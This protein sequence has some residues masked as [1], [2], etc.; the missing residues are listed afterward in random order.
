MAQVVYTVKKGD[1]L[2]PIAKKYGVT[3]EQIVKLNNLKKNS[4][5]NY[6]IYVG[7][8]LIISGSTTSAGSSGSTGGSSG[9][10]GGSSGSTGGSGSSSVVVNNNKPI[11][12]LFGLQSDTDRSI[13]ATW[14]WSK[15]H[16]D[17]YEVEWYYDSGDNVWFKGSIGTETLQQSIY[18]APS[19]AQRVKFRVK[20]VSE[21]YKDSNDKEISYWT[22]EFSTEKIY[23]F[24]ALP[25]AP[26]V[27][28][29]SVEGMKLTASISNL[30]S[31]TEKVSFE[32]V[33]DD[34]T[35][36][37][38]VRVPVITT[39]AQVIFDISPGHRYKVRAKTW[40]SKFSSEWSNYSDNVNTLP[41]STTNIILLKA[42]STTSVYIE[43]TKEDTA[44]SYEIEYSTERRYLENTSSSS[45]KTITGITNTKYEIEGLESGKEYFF[46]VR[47]VN[48]QGSSNYA[49]IK[50]IIL[51]KAPGSPTTW[52]SASVII[53]G[54]SLVLNW[55]HNTLDG[56]DLK[57]SMLELT[58][59]DS[60]TTKEII[61]VSTA[62]DGESDLD[63]KYVID[64]KQY[65]AGVSLTWR[66]KTAGITGVYGPWSAERSVKIYA[67]PTLSLSIT[68][69]KGNSLD[70][71]KSF[72]FYIKALTGPYTQTPLSFDVRV[73]SQYTYET[74][75]EYGDVKIVVEGEEIFKK[76][77][78]SKTLLLEISAN[79]IDLQ[80]NIEYTLEVSVAM[81]SGLSATNSVDFLVAWEEIMNYPSAEIVYNKD[82]MV[83]YI[84]PYCAQYKTLYYKVS[85][86][87]GKYVRTNTK[88]DPCDGTLVDNAL[89]ERYQDLIYTST[90]GDYFCMVVVDQ[91]E[92]IND[93][94]LSVYRKSYDGEYVM[95][96]QDIPNKNIYIIDPHPSLSVVRY[97]I[98]A[99]TKGTGSIGYSDEMLAINDPSIV[100]QWGDAVSNIFN[101]DDIENPVAANTLKLLYN[102]DIAEN[103]K[104]DNNLIEYIG[105]KH[106]VSYY[107]TQLG[108]SATW[109]TD[110]PE[111]D[112][113][114][115]EKL[116]ELSQY[117]GD[118]YVREP[119]GVGYWANVQVSFSKKHTELVVPVTLTIKRVEGG[120]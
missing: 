64:R 10:T 113:T 102:I 116:R 115:I 8:K 83:S 48:A 19:N 2:I 55:V 18:N 53:T 28:K 32:L 69:A 97:R 87:N 79:N 89:T 80:N 22:G 85:L 70:T 6:L 35:V 105:R 99:K 74:V 9:S 90:T 51:G 68:D 21:K 67:R 26:S 60:T 84:R 17:H 3:V 38:T 72:P 5:G 88:I 111:Y 34:K 59:N 23:T 40:N 11:I 50:S 13:F 119:S 75:D 100:L 33:Q 54:D 46:H 39:Y 20:A 58:F 120:V 16:T 81:D 36:V 71:I 82:T 94:T 92:L 114:T 47:A 4:R 29:I 98:V 96:A 25:T 15:N 78:N 49:N 101:P 7:Q 1:I 14:T 61:H 63:E 107:G 52:S 104:V 45:T 77:Y 31:D 62:T 42:L 73:I 56:S 41:D 110:V 93:V 76:H 12:G 37:R 44:T 103:N 95:L 30:P 109:N 65:T 57:K 27:P 108:V 117:T 43:W 66:V 91:T 24:K 106:P 118:V 86:S 112:T